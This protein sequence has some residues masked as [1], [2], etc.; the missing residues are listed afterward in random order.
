M[1]KKIF[2][3][4]GHSEANSFC[5]ALAH[6]FTSGAQ[7]AGYEVRLINLS[8]LNFD[9]VLAGGF[10]TLQELE[11]DLVKVHDALA[12]CESFT[13]IHPLWWG[14]APA[15]LKGLIDRV[16]LPGFAFKYEKGDISPTPLL[17]G[18]DAHVMITSD[19]PDE[20]IFGEFNGGWF[21]VLKKQILGFC[22]F[23]PLSMAS[24]GPVHAA[25]SDEREVW[26]KQA[27]STGKAA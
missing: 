26:L 24:I 21:E 20:Y 16:L 1:S 10:A 22:G 23:T 11:P 2:V 27:Y 8:D 4:N 5:G 15:K 19:T 17:G 9:P 12:W 25:T 6:E 14:S 13:L 3:L 18:R 7:D